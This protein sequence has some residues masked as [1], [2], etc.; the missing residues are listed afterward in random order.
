V[1][2]I[3]LGDSISWLIN[4]AP[5]GVTLLFFFLG[6]FT[7]GNATYWVGRGIAKGVERSRFEKR[8]HA[9]GYLKAQRFIQRWG[10]LAVPLSFL[11]VGVQSAV[12]LSAGISKMPLRRYVPAVALGA[13]LWALIYTSIG[14]AVFYAWL[15]L[16]WPW[17]VAG[18]VLLA[19]VAFVVLR[20]RTREREKQAPDAEQPSEIK[21]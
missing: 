13:A 12:N 21:G 16:D 15:A 11:T 19:I 3:A 8:L 4:D 1:C 10:A 5:F 17:I 14:M 18:I 6:A 2:S 7:R 20:W 9:P